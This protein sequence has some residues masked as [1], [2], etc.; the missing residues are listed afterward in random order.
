ML[1]DLDQIRPSDGK[2]VGGKAVGL[3]RLRGH[4]LPVPPGF[5]VPVGQLER[6]LDAAGLLDRV[7]AGAQGPEIQ[8]A[9]RAMPV[10]ADLL[11]EIERRARA[12][13]GAMAIRSSAL[14]EDGAEASH[15]GQ[16]ESVIGVQ[17][18]PDLA[19]ALR[20]VWASGLAPRVKLYA[21][22]RRSRSP[23]WA[24]AVVIQR[25]V[26]AGCAGVMFTIDP[27]TGSWR[28]MTVEAAPGSGEAVVAGQVATD[29]HRI[30]RPRRTP[31][32]LQRVLARV[33]LAVDLHQPV[34]PARP[35]LTESTLL[36][37]CRLGLRVEG[38]LG[39]PQDIE[40]VEDRSGELHLLQSR[41][42]STAKDVRRSGPVVWS[43]RFI[44]ERWTAPATPL[45][46][47]EMQHLLDRFI[48][49]PQT[50]RRWLGGEEPSKL[51]RFA[52][53]LNVT[54][55]RHL[56]F[57]L[58]GFAPP[59]F[60]VELLPPDEEEGWLRRHAQA[61]NLR[62]YGSI[63]RETIQG[64]RWTRFRWN[65]ATNWRAWERFAGELDAGLATM[66]GELRTVDEAR[67]RLSAVR[68][69]AR[70]YIKIHICSLLFANIGH[71]IC[72]AVLPEGT[73]PEVVLRGVGDNPTVRGNQALWRLGRGEAE[74]EEI[75]KEY[76]HRA[77]SSWELFSLRWREDPDAVLALAASVARGVDPAVDAGRLAQ[78]TE[79]AMANLPIHLRG[80]V[81]L[82]QRYLGLRE[83]QRFAFDRLLWSWKQ[84]L[85]FLEGE[86]GL[87]IRHLERGE[88]EALLDGTLPREA[89]QGMVERRAAEWSLE[90]ERRAAGNL[91]PAFMVG[92]EAHVVE[93]TG[94][95][96]Q[97]LGISSGVVTGT[98]RVIHSLADAAR[99]QPGDILVTRATDP[100]WA[101]L[102][103]T[104]GGLILEL[105]SMLSH[106][107]VVAREYRLPAV[108]NV[109]EATARLRDG[110]TVT[111]DGGR[112]MV[113]LR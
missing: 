64:R 102:F 35:V 55:F 17:P 68:T 93:H 52:P 89:A 5:V 69:L 46:W 41:P 96:I 3:A 105:G 47:S 99:L 90:V 24:L 23:T 85:L 16:Y 9:V 8:A 4:R 86:L 14:A 20:E 106:G 22:R 44:G 40:W 108:V 58:P 70:E 6:A 7:R 32:P 72:T 10:P 45:G 37:L 30:K 18:G 63:M 101:P 110:Q 81:R 42:V 84:G 83:V 67:A 59:K 36:R 76:G 26:E 98:V 21:A 19:D 107:A 78:Q 61:P 49:Y 100:G 12:L 28:H 77:P 94:R 80:F 13:G 50:S 1:L 60:M 56:G 2:R 38:L 87:A 31:R 33:R 65:P 97:G 11:E 39:G 66:Q 53:Y 27:A 92:G 75:L 62:V 111:L 113:W 48:G 91:P 54:V 103:L 34:D 79:A 29:F 73:D 51:V 82:T 43:S 57:K 15:A 104:A 74:L 71:Q 25:V 95:G 109:A 112:G 88:L